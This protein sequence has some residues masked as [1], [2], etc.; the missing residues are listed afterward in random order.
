MIDKIAMNEMSENITKPLHTK[1]INIYLQQSKTTHYVQSHPNFA[2]YPWWWWHPWCLCSKILAISPAVSRAPKPSLLWWFLP[3]S[4]SV[5]KTKPR[6]RTVAIM[7]TKSLPHCM[8]IMEDSVAKKC[9]RV[10]FKD[11]SRSR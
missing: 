1:E 4:V 3:A 11:F 7:K 10:K 2:F 5:M 9:I 8:F 6:I